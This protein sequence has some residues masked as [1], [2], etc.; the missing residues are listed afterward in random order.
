MLTLGFTPP[1]QRSGLGAAFYTR[2][3]LSGIALGYDHGEASWILEDNL[4]MV[5]PLERMGAREYKRYRIF[6]RPI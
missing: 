1:Y 6:E 4:D 5:R 3:W 2:A